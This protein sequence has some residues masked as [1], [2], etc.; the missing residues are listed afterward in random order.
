MEGS[1]QRWKS[2]IRGGREQSEVE[3]CN[4][5]CR[6]AIT[7]GGGTQRWRGHSEMEVSYQRR[8]GAFIGGRTGKQ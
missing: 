5:R 7:G 6:E 8:R 2:V 3:G 1:N 4:Q